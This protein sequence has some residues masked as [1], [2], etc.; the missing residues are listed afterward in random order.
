MFS[1]H[2]E[3]SFPAQWVSRA[4]RDLSRPADAQPV[5]LLIDSNTVSHAC[6]A[7]ATLLVSPSHHTHTPSPLSCGCV[8]A[9]IHLTRQH[10][11]R[12]FRENRGFCHLPE[13]FTLPGAGS[14]PLASPSRLPSTTFPSAW[15]TRGRREWGERGE[16]E[17]EYRSIWKFK[18]PGWDLQNM[19]GGDYACAWRIWL[20]SDPEVFQ[21]HFKEVQ[22]E[23]SMKFFLSEALFVSK[24]TVWYGSAL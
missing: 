10:F 4:R 6:C 23:V 22:K 19:Q 17:K 20:A 16:G 1:V 9:M 18:K 15:R 12:A 11:I 8:L 24:S 13:S 2:F 5:N 7:F 21:E 14:T 3:V